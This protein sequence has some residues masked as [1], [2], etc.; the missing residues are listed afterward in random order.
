MKSSELPSKSSYASIK[1]FGAAAQ[2]GVALT[3]ASV[4]GYLEILDQI[5]QD[6]LTDL[7]S[8]NTMD[9]FLELRATRIVTE[10]F[11]KVLRSDLKKIKRNME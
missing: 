9:K 6:V 1:R 2:N 5:D 7:E 10:K 3:G 11:R 4:T 8:A